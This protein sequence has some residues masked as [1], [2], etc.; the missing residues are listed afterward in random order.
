[1]A[2]DPHLEVRTGGDG[3]VVRFLDS[4]FL[5][6]DTI[7]LVGDQLTSLVEEGVKKVVLDFSN[8]RH[9]SSPF[10]GRLI[11]LHKRLTS[12]GG[13]L[14]FCNIHPKVY[15]VLEVARLDR[16]FGIQLDPGTVTSGVAGMVP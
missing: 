13:T 11:A 15:L 8:V 5:D 6:K 4:Q 16:L 3:L 10:L 7:Q 14:R 1:M 9:V 2:G 12:G